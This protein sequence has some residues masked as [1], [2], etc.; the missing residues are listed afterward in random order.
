RE[1]RQKNCP[2]S[3]SP[4]SLINFINR[5]IQDEL[6]ILPQR[7]PWQRLG[8]I[9]RERKIFRRI[10]LDANVFGVRLL[11]HE[12]IDPLVVIQERI[13]SP[14][15]I[16]PAPGSNI[17]PAARLTRLRVQQS[18]PARSRQ[19]LPHDSLRWLLAHWRRCFQPS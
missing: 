17:A 10:E 19:S 16:A 13:A 9:R 14:P 3:F 2:K 18:W 1:S 4:M 7:E 15:R 5:P 12:R 11:L 8:L 6:H